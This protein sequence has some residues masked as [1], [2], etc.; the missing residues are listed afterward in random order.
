MRNYRVLNLGQAP[1]A[2]PEMTQDAFNE[3][4]SAQS[5]AWIAS[6]KNTQ[7]GICGVVNGRIMQ[8]CRFP[9]GYASTQSA[10]LSDPPPPSC[11]VLWAQRQ[12]QASMGRRRLGQAAQAPAGVKPITDAAFGEVLAAPKAVALFFSPGCPYS[13]KFMPI[14]QGIAPQFPD[15]LFASVNVDQDV[16]NA[17]T[18][19]VRMLPTAVFFVGGK[20]VNRIDGVQD[21]GDFTGEMGRAFSGQAPGAATPAPAPA[22]T[23][24]PRSG[25]LVE[26]TAAPPPSSPLP[27]I[28][29]GVAT[30][31]VL[32]VIGYLVLGGK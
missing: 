32:G 24:P 25:T 17:G 22:A 5:E 21:Q 27:L 11:D 19:K 9:D 28:L 1:S 20:E 14:Y 16:K 31:G 13:Q 18:Y 8:E 6:G 23:A 3:A 12:Q 7:A 2:C 30:L 29:G 26:A 15:V 10:A 4:A